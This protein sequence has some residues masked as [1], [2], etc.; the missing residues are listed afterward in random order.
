MGSA[1]NVLDLALVIAARSAGATGYHDRLAPQR[2]KRQL[3]RE[4]G[5]VP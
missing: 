4:L 1:A 2:R 5:R 3:I